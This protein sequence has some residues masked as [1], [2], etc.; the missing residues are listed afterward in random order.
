MN[1]W[2]MH[3]LKKLFSKK[4]AL[5][6]PV[7]ESMKNFNEYNNIAIEHLR[8]LCRV[9][10][11]STRAPRF[12]FTHVMLPHAP[13]L[14]GK[15]GVKLLSP[16]PG[17]SDM[18]GYLGQLKYCNKLI[19]ELT[20]CLLADTTRDKIIIFQGD[21]GY[22]KHEGH[23][24]LAQFGALNAIYL[25]NKNYTGLK[26]DLSLVNT[27]RMVLNNVFQNNLDFLADSIVIDSIR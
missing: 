22:R 2:I 3:K 24:Y 27:Y 7:A 16:Q 21:H 13:Y 11:N 25:Y 14:L 26:K 1:P 9:A 12:S 6:E 10:G 19:R 18:N 20:E 5:P 4:E 23:S 15:N 17:G 8:S